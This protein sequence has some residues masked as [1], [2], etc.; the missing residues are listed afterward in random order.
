MQEAAELQSRPPW[1]LCNEGTLGGRAQFCSEFYVPYTPD[2][3]GQLLIDKCC[4]DLPLAVAHSAA[5]TA[6][7]A[8]GRPPARLQEGALAF[9]AEQS[10][11][12]G[13]GLTDAAHAGPPASVSPCFHCAPRTVRCYCLLSL[14]LREWGWLVQ[15]HTARWW[16]SCFGTQEV[17]NPKPHSF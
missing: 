8:P 2:L 1:S 14:R 7:T 15:S 17:R 13:A 9:S 6:L 11:G 12:C 4:S 10:V 3:Q 5:V 16:Q